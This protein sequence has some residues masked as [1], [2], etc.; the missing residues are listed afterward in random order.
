MLAL[1]NPPGYTGTDNWKTIVVP[2]QLDMKS[3]YYLTCA[4][5]AGCHG[6]RTQGY[7]FSAIHGLH[8]AVAP[9]DLV[10][11]GTTIKTSYRFLDG[12]AGVEDPD[13]EYKA[14][15]ILHNGYQGAARTADTDDAASNHTISHLCAECHGA[16]HNVTSSP[17]VFTGVQGIISGDD[18]TVASSPWLRH[19]TDFDMSSLPGEYASYTSYDP[20]VPV[21][22]TGSPAVGWKTDNTVNSATNGAIV[23]CLSCHRAHG[24]PWPDLLRWDYSGMIAGPAGTTINGVTQATGTGCFVCH[25]NKDGV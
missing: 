15:S 22:R 8:H 12:V 18:M 17:G 5:I 24:S 20:I 13:W 3:G 2:K 25:T 21:G 7:N 16:F 14:S 4:G 1:D 23:M 11:D 10:F 6:D 9:T 19:P